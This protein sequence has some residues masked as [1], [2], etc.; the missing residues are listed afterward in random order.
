MGVSNGQEYTLTPH[1]SKRCKERFGIKT[2]NQCIKWARKV[3]GGALFCSESKGREI[4]SNGQADIIIEPKTFSLITCYAHNEQPQEKF[5]YKK[6]DPIVRQSLF[7][8][9][10]VTKNRVLI[11]TAERVKEQT[12]KLAELTG[13]IANMRNFKYLEKNQALVDECLKNIQEEYTH[14]AKI[15]SEIDYNFLGDENNRKEA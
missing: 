1:F 9:M 4:W 10:S 3:M 14:A 13:K 15:V 8:S 12:S 5:N 6:L 11:E 7:D 2:E